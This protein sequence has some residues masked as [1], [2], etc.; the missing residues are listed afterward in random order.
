MKRGMAVMM[1]LVMVLSSLSFGEF[2]RISNTLAGSLTIY[3]GNGSVLGHA[4]FQRDQTGTQQINIAIPPGTQLIRIRLH[5]NGPL[6]GSA[7]LGFG[8]AYFTR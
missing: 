2:G 7:A 8:N 6:S 3:C 5:T 4:S 1:A